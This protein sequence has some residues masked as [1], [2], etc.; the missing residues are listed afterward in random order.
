MK[1]FVLL[2][3]LYVYIFF[4]IHTGASKLDKS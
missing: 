1:F 3:I 4:C 2:D